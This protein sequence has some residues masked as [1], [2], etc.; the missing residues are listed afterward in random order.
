ME[1]SSY[2]GGVRNNEVTKFSVE[3]SFLEIARLSLLPTSPYDSEKVLSLYF[4]VRESS[5]SFQIC[6]EVMASFPS[7]ASRVV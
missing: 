4:S 5:I 6:M 3:N 2:K 7:R 1:A